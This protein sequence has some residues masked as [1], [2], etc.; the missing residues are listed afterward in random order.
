M[1][2]HRKALLLLLALSLAM[3]L[4]IAL[5]V[6][7]LTVEPN[8]IHSLDNAA[9]QFLGLRRRESLTPFVLAVTH[10]GDGKFLTPLVLLAA[11]FFAWRQ[12]RRA[13][14]LVL[15]SG[16]TTSAVGPLLKLFF[17][18]A[19]PDAFAHLVFV[20]TFSFPSNHA[21]GAAAIYLTLALQSLR[22]ER[23]DSP[24]PRLRSKR[25]WAAILLVAAIDLSR[26]YLGVHYLSDVLAG[27]CMGV[28]I[29]A[30]YSLFAETN[31]LQ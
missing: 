27:T 16:V 26:I 8:W 9:A 7:G 1:A 3:F 22:A 31:S 15:L 24:L 23:R 28:A 21:L 5:L 14:V 12:Q 18:R 11:A 29:A 20:D 2:Q 17:S 25:L 19:R 13:A 6:Q 30:F 4:V 10:L